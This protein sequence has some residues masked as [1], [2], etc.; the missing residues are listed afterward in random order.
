[1]CFSKQET[2]C[3]RSVLLGSFRICLEPRQGITSE[4]ANS[5]SPRRLNVLFH[6][7]KART[8][9][10]LM[11]CEEYGDVGLALTFVRLCHFSGFAC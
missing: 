7:L 6:G 9:F 3:R 2:H 10:A 4:E 5:N 1:M 11:K 8:G